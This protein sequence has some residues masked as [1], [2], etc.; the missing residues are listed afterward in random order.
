LGTKP[1]IDLGDVRRK[2]K[3][4]GKRHEIWDNGSGHIVSISRGKEDVGH[5]LLKSICT[6]LSMTKDEFFAI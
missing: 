2:L 5:E 1:V 3:R 4:Q 6:E